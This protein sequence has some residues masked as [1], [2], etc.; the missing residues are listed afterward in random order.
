MEQTVLD[1]AEFAKTIT[2]ACDANRVPLAERSLISMEQAAR[3]A[4]VFKVLANNTRLRIVHELIRAQEKG[5]TELSSAV[6]LK[7]QAVSNQL[8]RLADQGVVTSRQEGSFVYYRLAD[9][10]THALLDLGLC[11]SEQIELGQNG[12]RDRRR[13]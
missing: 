6:G 10:C 5:V 13:H 7:P 9:P 1:I 4:R 11:M 8:Q 2:A 12:D 3:M